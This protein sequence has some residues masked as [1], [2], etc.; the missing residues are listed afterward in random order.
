[1]L[2]RSIQVARAKLKLAEGFFCLDQWDPGI[3]YLGACLEEK[4]V[5]SIEQVGD[6]AVGAVFRHIGSPLTWEARL[7]TLAALCAEHGYTA[8]LGDAFVRHLA[9]L[10]DSPLN[11]AGLDQWLSGWESETSRHPAM[12]LPLRLVRTGIAYLKTQPRDETVLLQLQ[13]EER[14]LVRQAL[15]LP[16]EQS[17]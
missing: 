4:T 6:A 11:S 3:K 17:E 14:T 10:A 7:A 15:G 5:F 9:K 1:M 16:S 12:Q 8:N 13:K 2:F